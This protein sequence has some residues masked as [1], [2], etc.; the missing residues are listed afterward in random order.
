MLVIKYLASVLTSTVVYT[1]IVVETLSASW[2]QLEAT[3]TH[4]LETSKSI[5][6]LSRRYAKTRLFKAFVN[7]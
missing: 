2:V 5:D 7:I 4:A 6:T 1:L 3:W